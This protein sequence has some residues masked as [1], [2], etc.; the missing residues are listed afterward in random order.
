MYLQNTQ[1]NFGRNAFS[2]SIYTQEYFIM[3]QIGV[4][5]NKDSNKRVR[6]CTISWLRASSPSLYPL[7]VLRANTL[8]LAKDP[9]LRVL[10]L[11][12][13]HHPLYVWLVG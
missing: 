8:C 7:A 2:T 5:M 1:G 13:S 4:M 11:H 3:R 10:L 9:R 6:S 12:F